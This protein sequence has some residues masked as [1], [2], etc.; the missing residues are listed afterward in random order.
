MDQYFVNLELV[1]TSCI[2]K[3]I[4]GG[5]LPKNGMIWEFTN[6]IKPV[7]LY[8]YLHAKYGKPNGVQ[9]LL[10]NNDSDN[11]I[12]WDWTF[13]NEHGLITVMGLN[14]RTEVHLMG[15]FKGRGLS[16]EMF[17]QQI[18][19]DFVNHGKEISIFKKSLEKWTQF[20]NPHHRIRRAVDESFRQLDA[21]DLNPSADRVASPKT[22][23]ESNEFRDR[24]LGLSARYSAGIGLVFGLRAMLPVL[25]ES[26]INFLIFSLAKPEVKSN[27]RL[28][29]AAV[30]QAI[31][32]RV[33]SLHLNCLGFQKPIDYTAAECKQ[34][35]TLMNDRN[36]LLH[37]NVEVSKLSIGDIYFQ[38]KTPLFIEYDDVWSISIG[39]SMNSVRFATVH[40]DHEIV[41]TFIE[42]IIGHLESNVAAQIRHLITIPY[43]G[44]NSATGRLGVLIP[45]S[46]AD[47]RTYHSA[48]T[49]E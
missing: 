29:N 22:I 10:K 19:S 26:F 42:Y 21:L 40:S 39:A 47:F 5:L 15:D 32:I 43:L 3:I 33:Q 14:F 17:I 2:T 24:W 1:P 13:A 12:H 41:E 8:C 11:L 49:K 34:F 18:K 30:R 16:L 23:D 35:H 46:I 36:D 20:V 48:E 9:T 37:G 4:A 7:D 6:E 27:E 44:F 28:F 31:D 45:E 25:A 38:E